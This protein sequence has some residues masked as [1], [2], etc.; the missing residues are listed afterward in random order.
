M[1][2]GHR[3]LVEGEVTRSTTFAI[4]AV[5]R[6]VHGPFC[7]RFRDGRPYNET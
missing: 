1:S 7:L 3:S 4:R 6:R 2:F 5:F